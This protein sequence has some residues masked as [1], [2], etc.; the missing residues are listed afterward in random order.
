MGLYVRSH[1][2]IAEAIGRDDD[3]FRVKLR[4]ARQDVGAPCRLH[5]P[6]KWTITPGSAESLLPALLR[7]S[8][9]FLLSLVYGAAVYGFLVGYLLVLG[10][11]I[12]PVPAS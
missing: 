7:A 2:E 5:F 1:L 10:V 9:F 8:R 3:T 4:L 12:G 6:R 11:V